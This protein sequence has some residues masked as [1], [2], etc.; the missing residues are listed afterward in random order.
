MVVCLL[1]YESM[2]ADD[3]A[4]PQIEFLLHIPDGIADIIFEGDI[5]GQDQCP[6]SCPFHCV[7]RSSCHHE[8]LSG[9]SHSFDFLSSRQ[10]PDE[11][12]LPFPVLHLSSW[13][14]EVDIREE[15][16]FEF[17]VDT[18]IEKAG[19]VLRQYKE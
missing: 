13:L 2:I 12:Q 10:T 18:L 4:I 11:I 14:F 3:I 17:L 15:M 7:H 1:I 19:I 5:I 8:R 9:S 6:G 16:F